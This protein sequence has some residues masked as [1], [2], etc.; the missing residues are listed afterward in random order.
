MLLF[1]IVVH[2]IFI[3]GSIFSNIFN[4]VLDKVR[5]ALQNKTVFDNLY[6]E[7][8]INGSCLKKI[9]EID[10]FRE[11]FKDK[12]LMKEKSEISFHFYSVFSNE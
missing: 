4:K 3:L 2:N 8:K 5:Q 11:H 10:F 7:L 6:I 12:K 9:I 1:A